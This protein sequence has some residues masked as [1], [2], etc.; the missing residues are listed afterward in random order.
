MMRIGSVY[1]AHER[2]L[3]VFFSRVGGG[4]FKM[5]FVPRPSCAG[6]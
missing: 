2:F 1:A 6:R 5:F 4:G 3:E